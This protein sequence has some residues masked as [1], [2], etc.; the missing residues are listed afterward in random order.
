MEDWNYRKRVEEAFT[1]IAK[2]LPYFICYVEIA[3]YPRFL[4]C[5]RSVAS[6]LLWQMGGL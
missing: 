3:V 4:L 2:C 5:Q 1:L 6:T